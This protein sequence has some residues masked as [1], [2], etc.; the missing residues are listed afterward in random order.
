MSDR[1]IRL[2]CVLRRP[3]ERVC[4]A[5]TLE[6]CYLRWQESLTQLAALVEP[7]IPD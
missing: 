3:S 2:H 6:M 5:V 4:R 7:N 1:T